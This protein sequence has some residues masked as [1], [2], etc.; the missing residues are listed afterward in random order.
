M[1]PIRNII[2]SFHMPLFFFKSGYLYK[3]RPTKDIVVR[4]AKKV[5]I[6]YV[7]TCLIIWLLF[8]IKEKNWRWGISIFLANGTGTVWNMEG[9]MVGPLWFLVCYVIS[10]IGFH[11]VL[12]IKGKFAQLFVILTLWAGA[13]I[14]KKHYGL[15]PLGILNAVPAMCCIWM[16][17]Y[18][19]DNQI[20]EIVL[21]TWA[22]VTGTVIWIFCLLYGNLSM[23]GLT[24]KLWI[25]QLIGAFYATVLLYKALEINKPKFIGKLLAHVGQ[26]SLVIL[27]VHSVD[28]MLNLS[29]FIVNHLNVSNFWS[30]TLNMAFKLIFAVIGTFVINKIPFLNRVYIKN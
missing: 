26:L 22:M 20:R 2:F 7:I 6:P 28:Y 27:C 17:Y 16:G 11:Y 3:D 19:K 15:Q 14:I 5:L 25:F 12:K 24:Y 1:S 10:V 18:L 30:I 29:G 13:I 21:S 8:I 4:N 9:L 23:A